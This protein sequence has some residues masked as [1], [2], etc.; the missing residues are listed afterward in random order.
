[1]KM[2]VNCK[3]TTIFIYI[4]TQQLNADGWQYMIYFCLQHKNLLIYMN[5]NNFNKLAV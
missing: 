2:M 3:K 5:L 1:M 4:D